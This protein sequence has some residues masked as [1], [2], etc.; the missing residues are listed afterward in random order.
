VN[1]V[2]VAADDSLVYVADGDL[3]KVIR[4]QRRK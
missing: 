4:Y 2:A 1:P 3:A